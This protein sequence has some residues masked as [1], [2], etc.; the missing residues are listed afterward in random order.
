[1]MYLEISEIWWIKGIYTYKTEG[2]VSEGANGKEACRTK[3]NA[4]HVKD[5]KRWFVSKLSNRAL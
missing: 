3:E 4:N 5:K 1:M 2:Y